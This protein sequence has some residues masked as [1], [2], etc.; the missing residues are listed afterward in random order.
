MALKKLVLLCSCVPVLMSASAQA[1]TWKPIDKGLSYTFLGSVHAFLI[2][3]NFFK[4]GVV[5]AKDLGEN[6]STA[7]MLAKKSQ[8]V[9]TINGGFFSPE[10][11]S[12]GLLVRNGKI[13]NPLHPT[14]WWG[15]FEIIKGKASIIP[16]NFF[17]PN[18]NM[19]MALQVGP[20]LV[21]NGEIPKLKA[22][23]DR[24]SGIGIR[25]NGDIVIAVA[26]DIDMS[27]TGFAQLFQKPESEGG[28]GCAD[29][30]NLD[31]GNSTQFYIHWNNFELN[32]PGVSRVANGIAI[33]PR[34]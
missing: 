23:M 18:R 20:R 1:Y 15:V 31:G 22:S 7:M 29:A 16:P 32:V 13:L 2:D 17:E 14:P 3:P 4:L 19:E 25:P 10:H 33:F 11:K 12:L 8:A 6:D 28:F 30:L 24:R 21:V 34:R 9:L 27:M 5:T 26:D